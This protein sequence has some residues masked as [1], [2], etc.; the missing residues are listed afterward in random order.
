MLRGIERMKA[1][2]SR[3]GW[4]RLD[5]GRAIAWILAPVIFIPKFGVIPVL[6]ILLVAVVFEVLIARPDLLVQL[7]WFVPVLVFFGVALTSPSS[8]DSMAF[9]QTSAEAASVLFVVLAIEVRA[10]RLTELPLE[11]R[12]PPAVTAFALLAAGIEAMRVLGSGRPQDGNFD[13]VAAG[14]AAAA[15]SLA[16]TALAGSRLSDPDDVALPRVG[17]SDD[18]AVPKGSD[19]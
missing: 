11:A 4:S 10:F 14:L 17:G 5:Y 12:R 3:L 8:I 18:A 15:A 13:I 9:Y 1:I 2:H 6:A 16:I 7:G 19:G